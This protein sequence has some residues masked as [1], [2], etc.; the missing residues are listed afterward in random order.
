MSFSSGVNDFLIAGGFLDAA[1]G[2]YDVEK[3]F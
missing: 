2:D 1:V 3:I